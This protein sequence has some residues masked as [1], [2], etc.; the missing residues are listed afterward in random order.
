MSALL[1]ELLGGFM[2]RHL[3]AVCMG[4][5]VFGLLLIAFFPATRKY[6][7]VMAAAMSAVLIWMGWKTKL[8]DEDR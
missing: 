6:L 1:H 8:P 7:N 4:M 5:G 3:P 2:A